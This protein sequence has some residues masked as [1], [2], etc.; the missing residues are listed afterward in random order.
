MVVPLPK[1]LELGEKMKVQAK[2]TGSRA[3]ITK[4][5]IFCGM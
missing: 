5:L 4:T 1:K 2:S 3:P